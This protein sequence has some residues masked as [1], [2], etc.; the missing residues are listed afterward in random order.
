MRP[1][2]FLLILLTIVSCKNSSEENTAISYDF[3][4][5][6]QDFQAI[7]LQG[8]T[9]RAAAPSEAIVKKYEEKKAAYLENKENLDKLIW[10]GRFTAYMGNYRE[11]ID[12]YTQGLQ[13]FPEN[14]RLLRHRGHRYISVREF[15]K[16]VADLS[17]AAK[18]IEGKE[19]M[20]EEDG[21]PNAQNIPLSTMHGNIYYHLGLAQYLNRNLPAALD[22]Y[23]KCLSTSN[24]PDNVVSATH[25]IY[26]I[27]RRLGRKEAAQN[28]LRNIE[29]GMNVIENHSYY[30]A[31]LFYKGELTLEEVYDP[32]SEATAS[33]SAL[34]YAIGNWYWYNGQPKLAK[35]IY[36][37]ILSG[38]DWA[39][40]GY[41]AAETDLA[42]P[43]TQR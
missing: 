29:P 11:A 37:E 40:F 2:L 33:N 13:E 17:K 9:L 1:F 26:M 24:N 39:S 32:T 18:L 7:S 16:A 23:K 22:A 20:I 14:S 15:D 4:P 35:E 41:I 28:Y 6:D 42:K 25:W 19:N 3:E 10:Y 31:C 43:Y 27:Q 8:D 21:M 34:K 12:I 5:W 30:N 38:T 36:N